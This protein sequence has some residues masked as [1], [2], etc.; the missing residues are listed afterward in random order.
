MQLRDMLM[1]ELMII[2]INAVI[3]YEHERN[4]ISQTYCSDFYNYTTVINNAFLL[5]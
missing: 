4:L 2:L 1:N 3:I 5:L